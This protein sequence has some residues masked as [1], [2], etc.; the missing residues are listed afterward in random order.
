MYP[1]SVTAGRKR[2]ARRLH[3][4]TP[5]RHTC[6]RWA[7]AGHA[8]G[9]ASTILHPRQISACREKTTARRCHLYLSLSH[10]PSSSHAIRHGAGLRARSLSAISRTTKQNIGAPGW[11]HGS[12]LT[13]IVEGGMR[14]ELAR[15]AGTEVQWR[16]GVR[17]STLAA[18]WAIGNAWL[19]AS[20]GHIATNYNNRT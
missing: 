10:P 2:R 5:S 14:D 19:E 1:G 4:G 7:E 15:A 9:G 20:L 3:A 12:T 8:E 18:T 13:N 17:A 6:E 16:R 11:V